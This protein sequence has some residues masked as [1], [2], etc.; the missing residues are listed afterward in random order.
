CGR[1]WRRGGDDLRPLVR[2]TAV[3][4][5]SGTSSSGKSSVCLAALS[6]AGS[7]ARA[8]TLDLSRRGLAEM[9]SDSNDLL[10]V[11]DDTEKADEKELVNTIK[12]VVH[13]L[14]GGKSRRISRGADKYPP[15]HVSAFA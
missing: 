8:E 11:L 5:F 6:L 14:P 7:P 15:L 1:V 4:N 9:A 13:V 2:E 12:S 3:F 10:M